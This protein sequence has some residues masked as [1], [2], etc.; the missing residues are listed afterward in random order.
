MNKSSELHPIFRLLFLIQKKSRP[1]DG[2]IE[3]VRYYFGAASPGAAS[4]ELA[5]PSEDSPEAGA[6]ESAGLDDC[7]VIFAKLPFSCSGSAWFGLPQAVNV[8]AVKAAARSVSL[9]I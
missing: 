8:S 9:I 1:A 5:A 7:E 4:P 6:P 3:A 2:F